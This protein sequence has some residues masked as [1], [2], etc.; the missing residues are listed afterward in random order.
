MSPTKVS[1]TVD[2]NVDKKLFFDGSCKLCRHE[3]SWLGPKLSGK[4]ELIDISAPAFTGF[5]GVTRSAMLAEIHLWDGKRFIT[6]LPATLYYWRLA[7]LR[8]LPWL[9]SLPLITSL[10]NRA[11]YFWAARRKGCSDGQCDL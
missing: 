10:A 4:I 8:F 5:A 9:L 1:T 2:K 7:G 11:Y 3:M 6:A